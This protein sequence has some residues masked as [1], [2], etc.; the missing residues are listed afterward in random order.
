MEEWIMN[1]TNPKSFAGRN[2]KDFTLIELLLVISIIAILAALLLPALSKAREQA[3]AI[4]CTSMM[5]QRALWAEFYSSDYQ[6]LLPCSAKV[7]D[8]KGIWFYQ[9]LDYSNM[10]EATFREQGASCPSDTNPNGP[11]T[12]SPATA[13]LG[14]YKL[15]LLYNTYFGQQ[16][17]NFAKFNFIKTGSIRKPSSCGHI[18][19][20]HI[21]T[22]IGR[23]RAMPWMIQEGMAG[24]YDAAFR[25]NMRS[26]ILYLDGHTDKLSRLEILAIPYAYNTLG[27]GL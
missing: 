21:D 8:I 5:K 16:V 15:S 7:T 22:S 17:T 18:F 2:G 14:P 3:K 26:N 20:G 9:M 1:G 25:H 11:Y 6:Y 24:D 12:D 4:G 27:K 13:T 19:E 23:S 10:K